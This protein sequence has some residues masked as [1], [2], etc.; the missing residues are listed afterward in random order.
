MTDKPRSWGYWTKAKLAILADYLPAFLTAS[1]GVTETVY[2]DAFAGQGQ[3]T[4]RL[5]GETFNGSARIAI[6]AGAPK[7]FT[8]LRYFEMADKAAALE[9]QLQAEYPGRDIKVY[10]GDCN[11][12]IKE[13]LADLHQLRWAPTFAFLD[14]DGMELAWTTL[15]ALADH[16][17]GYRSKPGKREYKVELWLLFPTQGLI[18][19][20]AH[21]PAKLLPLHEEQATRLFGSES[22]R[23]ILER[24][25]ANELT[26]AAAKEEYVNLMRWRLERSLGY[27]RTHAFELKNTQGGNVYHMIFATDNEAGDRI[28]SKLYANALG[29]VPEMMQEAKDRKVG[30]IS[31]FGYEGGEPAQYSYSPPWQPLSEGDPDD[32]PAAM[33]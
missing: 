2:L 22:W 1:S 8:R 9:A 26:P 11:E 6:E 19:I 5:T 3:G 33:A 10:A 27:S 28:M 7:G 21:D 31:L 16:K 20:L 29:K 17:R 30:A 14:P 24:R 13:A 4:D 18:R 32:A 12:T 15:E 25:R 23:E